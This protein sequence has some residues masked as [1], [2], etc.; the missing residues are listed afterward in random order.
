LFLITYDEHGG[1]YDHVTPP[2]EQVPA[3]DEYIAPNGFAFDR[4]GVR[5]PTVAISP[6]IPKG[7][8]VH[9][10]LPGE[11]PTEFSAFDSTSVLATANIILGL[12]DAEPLSK[13]MA[14]ANTF[15]GLVTSLD[16]PRS[17]CPE[18]LV[19]LPEAS[20]GAVE[21]QRRKPLNDHLEDQ[22]L[23]YCVMNHAELH[24]N[25]QCPGQPELMH[26]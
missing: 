5:I 25:G 20:A 14:W 16:E 9:D 4:L 7:T 24:K 23:Y 22:L 8:V 12:E 17:D 21:E 18:Q 11:K 6:W 19:D 13:R 1:F 10:A 3:P 26:N 2:F 15:A